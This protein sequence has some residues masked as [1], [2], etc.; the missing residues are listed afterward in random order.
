MLNNF[1]LFLINSVTY[2]MSEI[3]NCIKDI[4]KVA[5]HRLN[6]IQLEI[7]EKGSG[8]EQTKLENIKALQR[9]KLRPRVMQNVSNRDMKTSFLG[10]NLDSPI[11]LSVHGFQGCVH[12]EGEKSTAGAA[13]AMNT[14]MIPSHI[15]TFTADD[16]IKAHPGVS[17]FQHIQITE[18]R[19]VVEQIIQ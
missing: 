16:I 19:H 7:I 13:K 8:D 10:F 6:K 18:P 1:G 17:L 3:V 9:I 15:S 2:K 4:E 12:P 11:A 14:F 5:L